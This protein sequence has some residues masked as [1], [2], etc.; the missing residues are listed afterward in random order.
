MPWIFA[1]W[2]NS[3]R[4][5]NDYSRDT[6]V[7]LNG[8]KIHRATLNTRTWITCFCGS[9]L[10]KKPAK[11]IFTVVVNIHNFEQYYSC[12]RKPNHTKG[13]SAT[14]GDDYTSKH[15]NT[16]TDLPLHLYSHLTLQVIGLCMKIWKCVHSPRG[17]EILRLR[18]NWSK[19]S[20]P[21]QSSMTCVIPLDHLSSSSTVGGE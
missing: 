13:C 9:Q 3:T 12:N 15:C 16:N 2:L 5:L 21:L 8:K 11:I 10:F 4:S 7:L 1:L 19:Y 18:T 6:F 14:D 20:F 17:S